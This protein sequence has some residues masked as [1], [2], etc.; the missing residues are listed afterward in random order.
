MK[1]LA[2]GHS[3]EKTLRI[4]CGSNLG[5]VDYESNTLPL[6]HAGLP[7]PEEDSRTCF[8]SQCIL[9]FPKFS[10]SFQKQIIIFLSPARVAQW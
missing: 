8:G 7:H 4:Q 10:L 2:L 6:R 9:L 1:C 3:H 5:P